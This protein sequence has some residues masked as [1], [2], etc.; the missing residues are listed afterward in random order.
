MSGI[1]HQIVPLIKS[2]D[3]FYI[4]MPVSHVKLERV[5]TVRSDDR[6][7]TRMRNVDIPLQHF[8]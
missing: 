2:F 1:A 4:F 6:S 8:H 7:K 5:T 3:V